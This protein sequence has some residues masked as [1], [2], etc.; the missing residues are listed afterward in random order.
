MSHQKHLN[1]LKLYGITVIKNVFSKK[2]C[3]NYIR[4]SE[5]LFLK[6][7]KK[8]KLILLATSLK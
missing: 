6:L 3:E 8:K 1:N 4:R 2:K 7:L 5:L